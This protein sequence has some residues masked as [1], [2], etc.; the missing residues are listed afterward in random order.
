MNSG[1]TF[2]SEGP[3]MEGTWYNPR[4][5]DSFTVRD[6]FFED[7]QF[8]VTTADGRYLKYEQIQDYIKSD[9]P[10]EMPKQTKSNSILLPPEVAGLLEEENYNG[11]IMEDDLA[12]IQGQAPVTLGNLKDSMTTNPYPYNPI[13]AMQVVSGEPINANYDI[14]SKALTKRTLPDFQIGIDWLG[15]P[16]KEMEMLM[17]LMDVQES[18]IVDWY[19][20]QVD[21]ETTTAMIKEV[22]KD[23]LMKQLHPE[24][25][26]TI[27][28]TSERV[29]M[30]PQPQDMDTVATIEKPVKKST[31]KVSKKK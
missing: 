30:I 31:K 23:Y 28:V 2:G 22:I 11:M 3:M 9:K 6:S 10:I 19:L 14:I 12:M 17:D 18:E 25:A 27:A 20:S 24:V 4:T 21:I 7:N 8:V 15:C 26:E 13:P 29:E 5:G 1:L 16:V